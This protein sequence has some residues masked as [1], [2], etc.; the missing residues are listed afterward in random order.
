MKGWPA[1]E[2][3]LSTDPQDVGCDEVLEVLDVYAELSHAGQRP[4][5]RYP[6]VAAHLRACS[7]C[8]DD[9]EGLLIALD[10]ESSP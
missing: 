8:A 6:G 5:Q 4:G 9:L 10:H 7:P 2:R 1:L 3:F